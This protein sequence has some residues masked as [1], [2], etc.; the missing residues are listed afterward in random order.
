MPYV[1]P[2]YPGEIPSAEDLPDRVDDKDYYEAARYNELKKELR[3]A[4]IELGVLPKGA[5]ADVAA[6]LDAAVAGYTDRGD[7]AAYDWTL[8]ELIEDGAYHDLDLSAIVP[9]GAKAVS[10]FVLY[11]ASATA[12]AVR[13]RKNGNTNANNRGQVTSAVANLPITGDITVACD[14]NR[15]IEYFLS[16]PQTTLCIIT[17]KGWWM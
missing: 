13:F 16:S 3:A 14:N 10:L 4:L 6:R 9:A 12:M 15:V 1:P 17:V 2:K 7:P 8:A 11:K 5:Y